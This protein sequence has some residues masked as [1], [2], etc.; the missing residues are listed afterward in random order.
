MVSTCNIFDITVVAKI[1]LSN[2]GYLNMFTVNVHINNNLDDLPSIRNLVGIFIL[3]LAQAKITFSKAI[4]VTNVMSL[5][6]LA[7]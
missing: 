4:A 2:K 5:M 6:L 1:L 7:L 3:F